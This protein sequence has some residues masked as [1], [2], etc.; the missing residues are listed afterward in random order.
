M[1]IVIIDY[2]SGNLHSV[3]AAFNRVVSKHSPEGTVVVSR[4]VSALDDATHIVLPGVG[5]FADCIAGLNA[6]TGMRE[7]MERR[8][9]RDKMS[10]LG[11]CVGMQMLLERGHEHGVHEGL[12]WIKGEVVP[13]A[14]TD[15]NLKIPHMGWNE[16]TPTPQGAALF[17]GVTQGD[18][19]Y[20]V[21]S[22]HAA[23]EERKNVLATVEYGGEVVA[24]IGRDNIMGTQFHPEKSQHIGEKVLFNFLN[25]Q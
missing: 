13:L 5:A 7:A 14:P 11:I 6:L 20:F 21:H 9:L 24:A 18:H 1:N 19:T 25:M 23:C 10:F 3:A 22:Y 12:G 4:E 8:V 2:D 15:K 17:D 16:I